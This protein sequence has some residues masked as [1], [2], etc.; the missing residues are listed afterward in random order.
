MDHFQHNGLLTTRKPILGPGVFPDFSFSTPL[1][2]EGDIELDE[3][4]NPVNPDDEFVARIRA[5]GPR[6]IDVSGMPDPTST[7]VAGYG[8]PQPSRAGKALGILG[9]AARGFVDAASTPNIAH[10]GGTDIMRGA[11]NAMNLADQRRMMQREMDLRNWRAQSDA[12]KDWANAQYLANIKPWVEGQRVDQGQQRINQTGEKNVNQNAHWQNQDALG[13]RKLDETVRNNTERNDITRG[14]AVIQGNGRNVTLGY[15]PQMWGQLTSGQAP[16]VQAPEQRSP[17]V[18]AGINLRNAQTEGAQAK[19]EKTQAETEW[20]PKLMEIRGQLA[21]AALM[22]ASSNADR[23][24][25][26]HDQFDFEYRGID[27]DGNPVLLDQNGNPVIPKAVKAAS[28][29]K[30]PAAMQTKVAQAHTIVATG[31]E[32]IKMIEE[33]KKDG[34]LGGS[35]GQGV[36]EDVKGVVKGA[37]HAA[38][39]AVGLQD[40]RVKALVTELKNMASLQ[41]AVHGMRGVT[42]KAD[43]DKTIGGIVQKPD[44]VIA[45]IRRVQSM[46]NQIITDNQKVYQPTNLNIRQSGPPASGAPRPTGQSDQV[47]VYWKDKT[48]AKT[49]RTIPRANLQ[50]ALDAGYTLN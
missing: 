7:R 38:A 12:A 1:P 49:K 15:Q 2:Y 23:A 20:M 13:G 19:T 18:Q 8:P 34:T 14:R 46:S 25:I 24:R 4:G 33:L 48:G 22:N 16:T 47:D 28:A 9:D 50:S 39:G 45:S 41:P 26:A 31:D 35:Q 3:N 29:E 42:A 27:Q 36:V 5:A 11:A 17:V 32:L 37:Y 40:T 21:R 6:Q 10:G 43:F 44:N 30:V